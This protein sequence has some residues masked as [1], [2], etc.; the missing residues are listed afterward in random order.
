MSGSTSS[1]PGQVVRSARVAWLTQPPAGG[2]R[3]TLESRA[4]GSIS[5]SVPEAATGAHETTPGELLAG[6]HATMMATALAG[7]LEKLGTP[8]REL[9]VSAHAAF[10]G[11]RTEREVVAIDLDVH[12][13]VPGL[14]QE[15]L[16]EAATSARERYLRLCGTRRD[17]GGTLTATLLNS[18][19]Q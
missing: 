16:E 18:E 13:R 10:N 6:A 7:L 12:A 4:F 14:E 3:I 11:P 17:L 5:M 1:E 19:R 2:G 8:A 9:V 15:A